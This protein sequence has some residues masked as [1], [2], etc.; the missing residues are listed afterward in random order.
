MTETAGFGAFA[1]HVARQE[2]LAAATNEAER[3]LYEER[4]TISRLKAELA[5]TITGRT[6]FEFEVLLGH[7]VNT[8]PD[9]VA[10]SA[11]AIAAREHMTRLHAREQAVLATISERQVNAFEAAQRAARPEQFGEPLTLEWKQEQ[12]E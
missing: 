7:A 9:K 5:P 1:H 10:A 12:G 3:A 11:R 6:E 8:H 4:L 2:E